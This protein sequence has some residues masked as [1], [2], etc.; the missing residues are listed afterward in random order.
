MAPRRLAASHGRCVRR[1]R[2][3][4]APPRATV[5]RRYPLRGAPGRAHRRPAGPSGATPG[6]STAP[7]RAPRWP[8][9][10]AS[11]MA[12]VATAGAGVGRGQGGA[13]LGAVGG[14]SVPVRR[15]APA[16]AY[17]GGVPR[18]RPSALGV[19]S[20]RQ[21]RHRPRRNG[22][23]RVALHHR[24]SPM[25]PWSRLLPVKSLRSAAAAAPPL[26]AARPRRSCGMVRG[27]A[28]W[29]WRAGSGWVT[30]YV[31]AV[32]QHAGPVRLRLT[33]APLASLPRG[34]PAGR[35]GR[36]VGAGRASASSLTAS[37]VNRSARQRPH[38]CSLFLV[39]S[40]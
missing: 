20:R 31:V 17:R 13:S 33:G 9:R 11:V 30:S 14:R 19:L 28:L 40:H 38:S 4:C 35:R 10:D 24:L 34:S 22:A 25:L 7:S 18:A 26:W 2:W 29:G 32:H 3:S 23:S 21:G 39:P 16:R 12:G 8:G 15:G 27:G 5:R 36:P 6:R 37:R 1:A